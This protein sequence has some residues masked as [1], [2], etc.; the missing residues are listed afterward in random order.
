MDGT[1]RAVATWADG[2]LATTRERVAG[3]WLA[4]REQVASTF[5]DGVDMQMVARPTVGHF[6]LSRALFTPITIR[7]HAPGLGFT[8]SVNLGIGNSPAQLAFHRQA[9]AAS[10]MVVWEANDGVR[11]SR[12]GPAGW[13]PASALIPGSADGSNPVVAMAADGF[14]IATWTSDGNIQ[15]SEFDPGADAWGPAQTIV[16]D[17]RVRRIAMSAEGDAVLLFTRL[18][19]FAFEEYLHAV[20]FARQGGWHDERRIASNLV[21][22]TEPQIAMD[23]S[24]RA[25][26]VWEGLNPQNLRESIIVQ[27]EFLPTPVMTAHP[28]NVAVN[29]GASAT[30]SCAARGLDVGYQW[31]RSNDGGTSWFDL[32]GAT[33]ASLT[34]ASVSAVDHGARLR[35]RAGNRYGVAFSDLAMLSVGSNP[36]GAWAALGGALNVFPAPSSVQGAPSIEFDA[37]ALPVVA[38]RECNLDGCILAVKRWTGAD[39]LRLGDDLAVDPGQVAGRPSLAIDLAAGTVYVAWHELDTG[40][41]TLRVFV[42]RWNGVAWAMVGAG[43]LNHRIGFPASLPEVRVRNGQPLVAW[44]ESDRIIVKEWTGAIWATLGAELGP[45]GDAVDI[46]QFAPRLVL[47]GSPLAPRPIVAWVSGAAGAGAAQQPGPAWESLGS[48][49]A[50]PTSGELALGLAS[51]DRPMMAAASTVLGTFD[52][53]RHDGGLLWSVMG[54]P[55]GVDGLGHGVFGIALSRTPASNSTRIA[56]SARI[57]GSNGFYVSSWDGSAWQALGDRIPAVGRYGPGFNAGVALA[58]GV[59]PALAHVTTSANGADVDK[60]L[61]VSQYK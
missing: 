40:G 28:Q 41:A 14:A 42:K 20:R 24:G 49:Y 13:Q 31:Q 18:S 4:P 9:D 7:D 11:Y 21:E 55:L 45:D 37:A 50:Q 53:H 43:E 57:P 16:S 52:V 23:D 27:H 2:L 29:D 22:G 47:G 17:A 38:F 8:S 12:R 10:S 59:Q 32:A 39:W 34:M 44:V 36:T 30:F 51:G 1:G 54:S 19:G 60:A 56:W 48:P 25:L 3:S 15:V 61:H 58:D 26:A 6:L 46:A 35:C 33:A 5:Y